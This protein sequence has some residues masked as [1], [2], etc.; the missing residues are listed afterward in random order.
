MPSLRISCPIFFVDASAQFKS[1]CNLFVYYFPIDP[2]LSLRTVADFC[3]FVMHTLKICHQVPWGQLRSSNSYSAYFF[4]QQGSLRKLVTPRSRNS[5]P[6]GDGDGLYFPFINIV[7][8]ESWKCGRPIQFA[9]DM[10]VGRIF[11][12]SL[13]ASLPFDLHGEFDFSHLAGFGPSCKDIVL[14][15]EMISQH[16][17]YNFL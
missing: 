15:E 14:T 2:P 8:C 11:A 13:M 10:Y 3:Q 4:W 12:D 17:Q 9:D 6:S 16:L 5:P 1:M 7:P